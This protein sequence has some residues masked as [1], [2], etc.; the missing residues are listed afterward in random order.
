MKKMFK[1]VKREYLERVKKKS[2]LIGTVL[3]PVIM[4]AKDR[5]QG[6]H[7]ERPRK[8]PRLLEQGSPDCEE[9]VL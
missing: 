1:V 3:G 6:F 5:D 9:P 2:F 4:R 8:I 7:H